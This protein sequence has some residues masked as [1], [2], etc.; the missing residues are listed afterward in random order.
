MIELTL[1]VATGLIFLIALAFAW[2]STKLVEEKKR[3]RRDR[4]GD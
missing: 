2:E 1:Q 4:K 3:R